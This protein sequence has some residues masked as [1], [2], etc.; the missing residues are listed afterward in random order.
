[1]G[2][3]VEVADA[4]GVQHITVRKNFAVNNDLANSVLA[5]VISIFGDRR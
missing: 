4:P 5:T 2:S 1:L 3:L